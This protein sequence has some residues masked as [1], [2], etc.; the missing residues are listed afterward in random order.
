M[1]APKGLL[2]VGG[3]SLLRAHV[4]AA[5]A[6]GLAVRVVLGF[7][8]D[9]HR[10]VLPAG[11]VV[12]ENAAWAVTSMGESLALALEPGLRALVTPVDVPP[13]RVAT[14]ARLLEGEGDAVPTHGG[15]DGHPVRLEPPHPSGRLDTRLVGARRVL[16]DDPDVLRN[17]NTPA[18]WVAW[19]RAVSEWAG[20]GP[21]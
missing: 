21:G 19:R 14:L 15:R 13:A 11:V 6:A 20:P 17:L 18:D 12:F 10:A 1:G 5:M 8:A 16:V 7:R 9:A 3:R 2:E 4:D